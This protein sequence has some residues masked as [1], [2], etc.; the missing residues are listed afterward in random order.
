MAM[1]NLGPRIPSEEP[2]RELIERAI[3]IAHHHGIS[4]ADFIQMM[5]SGIRISDFLNAMNMFA[6][7][8][9]TIDCG[10]SWGN[11]QLLN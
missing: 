4:S 6:D 8:A 7:A 9:H 3:E 11:P 5:D 1:N 2:D 10:F